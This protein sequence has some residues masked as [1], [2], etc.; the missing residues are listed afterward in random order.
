MGFSGGVPNHIEPVS[1]SKLHGFIPFVGCQPDRPFLSA[2]YIKLPS[3]D[4]L[5]LVR[6]LR[7][8]FPVTFGSWNLNSRL[9]LGVSRVGYSCLCPLAIDVA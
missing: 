3:S 5:V 4:L 1:I 8:R 2:S 9:T 6:F 7:V